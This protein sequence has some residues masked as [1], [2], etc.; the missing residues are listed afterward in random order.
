MADARGFFAELK[1]RN[2]VRAALVYAAAVWALA[3]GI[4]QLGP[5]FHAPEWAMRWFVIACAIGFP[6]WIAFAWFY[7]WTPQGFKR[8]EEVDASPA[9]ARAT[10][11]KLDFWIIGILAVAVV[12]LLTNTFVLH[13]DATGKANLADA[14]ATMAALAKLPVKSVAVLPL[15]NDS[16]DP[17]QAYFSD[18][19]SEELISDLTQIDGL[20]V[21]GRYSSFKFRDSTD[22]PA[23]IGA[24]LGVSNLIVGSVRQQGDRIRVIVN[25]IRAADG[26]SVWSHSYDQQLDDVFAIQTQIG[27]AVAAALKIKLLGHAIGVEERPPSGSGN[28][29]RLMLQGRALAR[30][31]V[32]LSYRKSIS[33]YQQALQIDPDYAYAWGAVAVA[34]TNLGYSFLTGPAQQKAYAQAQAAAARQ[35]A[36]APDAVATHLVR[37]AQLLAIAHD[38]QGAVAEFQKAYALAPNDGSVMGFLAQGLQSLGQLRQSV[39]LYRKAI[40]TDPM[41]AGFYDRLTYSL[42]ALGQ[43]D[44]AEQAARQALGFQPDDL[45]SYSNLM[46]IATARGQL[47]VAE[48]MARKVLAIEPHWLGVHAGLAQIEI[49]R[50]DADA[51]L[52]EANRETEPDAKAMALALA[53]QIGPDRRKADTALRDYTAEHGGDHPDNVADL[54]A[55]RKQPDE[56]F[57]WLQR[58]AA[59]RDPGI[60]SLLSDPFVLPFKHDPRFAKLCDQLGLPL[61]GQPVTGLAGPVQTEQPANEMGEATS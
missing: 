29:Y 10:G 16:G 19:L 17:K 18:G 39:E 23:Q 4:A 34:Q 9:I 42:L 53:M 14:K 5:L 46:T 49:L 36:L 44:A 2:V 26:S 38:T 30:K 3:Q 59:Q 33:L 57:E 43:L 24:A 13:R 21:I 37:G 55:V 58:A 28:A 47:D 41:R 32:E 48:Q 6:F 51:A 52:R 7:A 60:Y 61:P 54:Y 40:T 35:Q 8:E 25:L 27:E 11:R 50:G 15:A 45:W 31:G 22:S 12:L 56:M 20:K 1:R